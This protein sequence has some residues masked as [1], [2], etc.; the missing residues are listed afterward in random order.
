M[1]YK[2]DIQ[3]KSWSYSRYSTYKLCP[4]KAKK[5]ILEK[6]KEPQNEAMLRGIRVHDIAA[7][8]I[9][10]K[11][12]P[13]YPA[14]LRY[15]VPLFK[16]LRAG[17]KAHAS[18][19]NVEDSWNL[20]KQFKKTVW[21][22]WDGIWL[23]LKLDLGYLDGTTYIVYD[24]KTG[25]CRPEEQSQYIEQLELYAMIAFK[26]MP[27]V[28]RVETSLIYLDTMDTFPEGEPMA[29]ERGDLQT[30][31]LKWVNRIRPMLRDH[32]FLPR[33]NDKCKWCIFSH[34]NG[35]ECEF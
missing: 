30:L 22:D 5:T 32:D 27:W 12:F 14:E 26:L 20:T 18:L 21:N 1:A 28:T 3:I 16:K 17:Y 31:E 25:K 2:K 7:N 13:E 33:P 15:F 6:F 9:R 11:E 29:F 34:M 23:R 24:W 10:G 8:Y 4:R 19:Y 35:G